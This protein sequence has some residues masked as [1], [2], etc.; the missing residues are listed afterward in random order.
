MP[1][2]EEPLEDFVQRL[3]LDT[4]AE[5]YLRALNVEVLSKV[6]RDFNPR[7]TKDGNVF[8]RLQAFARS[9]SYSVASS[10]G[11]DGRPALAAHSASRAD[12]W[13]SSTARAGSYRH[14]A[15][16]N[17]PVS[18]Y[19]QRIGLDDAGAWLVGE[20]PEDV[21]HTVM[22][23]FNP[24]GTKDGNVLGRLLGF[25]R[26][27]WAQRMGLD[28]ASV[29]EVKALM[30]GLPEEA[31]ARI[32]S[33]FD[34][35]GTKDGNIMARLQRF[36]HGVASRVAGGSSGGGWAP[37]R[38]ANSN[39]AP[40]NV[41]GYVAHPAAARSAAAGALAQRS[42]LWDFCAALNLSAE[43]ASFLSGLPE[44]VQTAVIRGF[45]PSGTKDGN[46]WGRLFGFV[47][48]VWVQRLGLDASV[49]GFLKSLPEEAQRTII[50]K[51]DPSRTKD[52]NISA[53]LES[54]ARSVAGTG[55]AALATNAQAAALTPL[56][57]F[58][59]HWSLT[60]EA[61]QFL[62]SLPER[63]VNSV[64][65]SFD[66]RGTKDGNIWGRL[67]GFV[68]SV[69]IS[70]LD[71]D[72]LAANYLRSLPEEHQMVVMMKFD[73]EKLG[74]D[75]LAQFQAIVEQPV[76]F[77]S[78][79]AI[80][81]QE[82]PQWSGDDAKSFQGQEP[83]VAAFVERCGLDEAA[84]DFVSSL[85]PDVR[86]AVISDFDPGG[87]K[88]GNVFARLQG[89]ARCVG[90]RQKRQHESSNFQRNVKPRWW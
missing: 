74:E 20:L 6:I 43:A 25:A 15:A 84:A 35:T 9:V 4:E 28:P 88:D 54:F 22:L 68:R 77:K 60:E 45:D 30:R 44:E 86:E 42:P 75:T 12:T 80:S 29:Q 67:F 38:A 83:S 49:V 76:Q 3:S 58:M 71:V 66:A 26:S 27:V 48:S 23:E 56:E 17:S 51:F 73:P 59:E 37:M 89:F 87:T 90:R 82:A 7:G 16:R 5:E 10:P 62:A 14:G 78:P 61:V 69:W 50:V 31:Q 18:E 33:Q 47:R 34:A 36:A 85:E 55:V 13:P 53:R 11:L 46:V 19:A 41:S 72:G 40:A 24:S 2:A 1:A 70:H 32:M 65:H 52:G 63:V 21:Q 8:G 81:K 79:L 64:L 39:G 57:Q